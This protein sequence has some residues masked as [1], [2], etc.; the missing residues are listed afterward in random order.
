MTYADAGRQLGVHPNG[1]RYAAPT[2]RGRD[3]MGRVEPPDD[4]DRA[5]A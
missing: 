2:G 3:A 1:L 5:G 4:L